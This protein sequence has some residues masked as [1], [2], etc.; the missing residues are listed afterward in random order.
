MKPTPSRNT[1]TTPSKILRIFATPP[2]DGNWVWGLI[3]IHY[4]PAFSQWKSFL[5]TKIPLQWR[6]FFSL[7]EKTGWFTVTTHETCPSR[8]AQTTP[9]KILRIFATPPKDGN[10]M[11]GL[12]F[13]HYFPAFSQWISRFCTLK[14]PSNG[15][16]SSPS[17][18]DGVVHRDNSWNPPPHAIHKPPRQKFFEYSPPS[19][20]WELSVGFNFHTLFARVFQIEYL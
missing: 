5:H 1:Q 14:F 9:S 16:D 20:G 7:R 11:W 10:W 6:G 2:T 17:G 15:G 3:F 8:N 19:N 18:E 12:I 13:I 4:F